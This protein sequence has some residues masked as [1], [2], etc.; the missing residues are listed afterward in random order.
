MCSSTVLRL[1]LCMV[2][3]RVNFCRNRVL[4]EIHMTSACGCWAEGFCFATLRLF[5]SILKH[6]SERWMKGL[7]FSAFLFKCFAMSN[8]CESSISSS[9]VSPL[10]SSF[11]A[12][13]VCQAVWVFA[14]DKP[15]P[16]LEQLELWV[17]ETG[18]R[19]DLLNWNYRWYLLYL[20]LRKTYVS[21][22]QQNSI[23]GLYY[24]FWLAQTPCLVSH[25]F[26]IRS[27]G[28]IL[29]SRV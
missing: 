29:Y 15:L 20:V 28:T 24:V 18:D 17:Q 21:F 22:G 4:E 6:G 8:S 12:R 10:S 5:W 11:S 1:D 7:G 23:S 9:G 19:G 14:K 27:G 25:I 3:F 16:M 13:C 26:F 2:H